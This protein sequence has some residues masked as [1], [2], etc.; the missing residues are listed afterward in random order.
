MLYHFKKGK[1][2]T[3][4]QKKI[5]AVYGECAVIDCTCQRWFAKFP[6]GDFSLDEA[7]RL[8]TPVGVGR[9]QIEML[10]ENIDIMPHGR[11]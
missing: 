2:A 9:D 3:E 5:C 4:T 7:S 1:K 10:T 8:G 6:A 11:S